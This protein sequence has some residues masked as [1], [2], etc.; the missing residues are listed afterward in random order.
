MAPHKLTFEIPGRLA[1][2]NEL[3]TNRG[4]RIRKS[5]EAPAVGL[6][7]RAAGAENR[8]PV[9]VHFHCYEPNKRRD[10]DNFCLG[11]A[12]IVLDGLKRA[13]IIDQDGWKHIRGLS[14]GWSHDKD[15]P[16]VAVTL[17]WV[18]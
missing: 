2:T 1:A 8:G 18:P 11:A 12:K 10:P 6:L 15:N 7:A 5:S 9:R 17:E 14:F 4:A 3:L 16:R 13:G